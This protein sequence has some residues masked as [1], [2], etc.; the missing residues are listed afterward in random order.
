MTRLWTQAA[1]VWEAL[2]EHV[3]PVE[4]W[5]MATYRRREIAKKRREPRNLLNFESREYSEHGEDG[6]LREIFAR[7]G[8][9]N[10]CFVECAVGDGVT[11]NTRALAEH[12]GWRGLWIEGHP[13]RARRAE[14]LMRAWP[15]LVRS[16]VAT[17]ENFVATLQ[18]AQTPEEFDLL[19]LDIDGNDYWLWKSLTTYTPRV[20]VIEYNASYRPGQHWVMSY[21][22]A[23]VW[24]GSRHFGASLDALVA[25]GQEKQYALVACDSSG[26]NAFFVRRE[27]CGDRFCE[28]DG[29]AAAHY[30]CPNVWGKYFW[31]T[32]QKSTGIPP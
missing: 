11:N 6:I 25:L 5:R 26:V 20:V 17:R 28:A 29:G 16:A 12:H 22:P 7:I 15:V 27:L 21:D 18:E 14:E 32:W 2:R 3:G 8:V 19:S 31:L 23:H 1:I 30:V 4:R 24:R 10:Q 9:T 13:G